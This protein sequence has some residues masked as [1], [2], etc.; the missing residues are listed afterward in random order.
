MHT[1]DSLWDLAAVAALRQ[2]Q[3]LG[4]HRLALHLVQLH[5]WYEQIHVYIYIYIHIHIYIYIYIHLGRRRPGGCRRRRGPDRSRAQMTSGVH[6]GGFRTVGLAIIII[7]I[8][9]THKLLNPLYD[10]LLCELPMTGR[11]PGRPGWPGW[12]YTINMFVYVYIFTYIYIYVC[13]HIYIYI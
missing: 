3:R 5:T 6:K 11:R 12:P 10:T 8:R 13:I 7:I 9:I 1:Y 4:G 2:R